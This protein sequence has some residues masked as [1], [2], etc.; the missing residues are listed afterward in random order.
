MANTGVDQRLPLPCISHNSSSRYDPRPLMPGP[1]GWDLAPR[2][3][4]SQRLERERLNGTPRQDEIKHQNSK[5]ALIE[6]SK[7]G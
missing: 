2:T 7:Q 6:N 3:L 4:Y 5:A 1:G